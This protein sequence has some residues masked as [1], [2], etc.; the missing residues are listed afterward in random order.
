MVKKI[1]GIPQD[2]A[3]KSG[4]CARDLFGLV[5]AFFVEKLARWNLVSSVPCFCF[6]LFLS[7][8]AV[9]MGCFWPFGRVGWMF[10][11]SSWRRLVGG[12]RLLNL[13][14]QID[15]AGDRTL[16]LDTFLWILAPF[17]VPLLQV[18]VD[19]RDAMQE[20]KAR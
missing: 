13:C 2:L 7:E 19:H 3:K 6:R 20:K 14:V 15:R 5:L 8:C 1:L 12:S 4:T 11:G 18:I 10:R 16:T 17:S 9:V